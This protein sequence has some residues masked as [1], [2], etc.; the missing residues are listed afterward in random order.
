PEDHHHISH[1]RNFPSNIPYFLHENEGDPA[2]KNFLPKLKGHLLSWLAHP[3]WSGNGNEFT[4]DNYSKLLIKNDRLY[5]HKVLRVNYTT[6]DVCRGQ[7]LEIQNVT[8]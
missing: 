4:S 2:V 5:H 6:Y 7:A 1:S 8:K 3:D